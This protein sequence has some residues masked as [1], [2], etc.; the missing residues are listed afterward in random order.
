MFAPGCVIRGNKIVK[1]TPKMKRGRRGK[2]ATAPSCRSESTGA[3]L[4]LPTRLKFSISTESAVI[5]PDTQLAPAPFSPRDQAPACPISPLTLLLQSEMSAVSVICVF[6][7]APHASRA[8]HA[9]HASHAATTHVYTSALRI[10]FIM[11]ESSRPI[12]ASGLVLLLWPTH[13]LPLCVDFRF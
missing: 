10:W 1:I 7:L 12:I 2:R 9:T 13:N 3:C 5:H 4:K 11:S 8:T 6:C